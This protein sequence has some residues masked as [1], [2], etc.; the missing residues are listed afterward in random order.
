MGFHLVVR[1]IQDYAK[2]SLE[3]AEYHMRTTGGDL[4]LAKEYLERVA[5]SNAEDVGR[6]SELLKDVKARML[7]MAYSVLEEARN[8]NAA[9]VPA[10]DSAGV[11]MAT[12]P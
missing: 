5:G 4:M 10:S 1:P 11:E 3:V 12:D 7:D 2:S 8:K 9:V 6:A